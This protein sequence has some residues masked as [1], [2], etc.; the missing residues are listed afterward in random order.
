MKKKTSPPEEPLIQ[1]MLLTEHWFKE[2]KD[3]KKRAE[4]SEEWGKKYFKNSIEECWEGW[5]L[6]GD[7]L[8]HASQIWLVI[9]G[10]LQWP[11]L[12]LSP[13]E[14][15]DTKARGKGPSPPESS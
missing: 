7:T 3:P 14:S 2:L 12:H 10:S 4:I 5:V 11:I 1:Y 8:Q 13:G 9:N 15:P 6:V